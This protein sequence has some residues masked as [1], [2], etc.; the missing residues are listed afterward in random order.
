MKHNCWK[1]D[2]CSNQD[3]KKK[4]KKKKEKLEKKEYTFYTDTDTE[5]AEKIIDY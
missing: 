1:Q 5:V 2:G 4:Y 3:K